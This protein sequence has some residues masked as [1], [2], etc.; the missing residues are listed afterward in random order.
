MTVLSDGTVEARY[1]SSIVIQ[2]SQAFVDLTIE[3][4]NRLMRYPSGQQ[5]IGKINS[6]PN[7]VTIKESSTGDNRTLVPL[8]AFRQPGA[9]PSK[10]SSSEIEY[11]PH[12]TFIGDGKDPWETRPPEV[13]LHHELY[14]AYDTQYG[15]ITRGEVQS[16][17]LKGTPNYEMD[18]V[19]LGPSSNNP[20]SENAL[21]K[22]MGEPIRERYFD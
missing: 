6:N 20:L 16:G 9:P 5:L 10:G 11:N 14:H 21:R 3:S 17:P 7:Q 13:D 2:G 4:L 18:A 15:T 12:R 22:E 8:N 1:G 19:G